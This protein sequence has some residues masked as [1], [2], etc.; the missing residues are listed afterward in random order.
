MG[1]QQLSGMMTEAYFS[2]PTAGRGR[3]TALIPSTHSP[4]NEIL[5]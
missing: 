5:T 3:E 4:A 2:D 1:G